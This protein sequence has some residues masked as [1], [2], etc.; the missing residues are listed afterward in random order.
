MFP[1]FGGVT[2]R[3]VHSC[4]GEVPAPYRTRQGLVRR[5]EVLEHLV[6]GRRGHCPVGMLLGRAQPWRHGG[7]V[8]RGSDRCPQAALAGRSVGVV[9]EEA[10]RGV[11]VGGTY[12]RLPR[13]AK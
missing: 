1:T 2:L 5:V 11:A 7:F 12:L 4:R 6:H 9:W 13:R 3:R 10:A 8:L